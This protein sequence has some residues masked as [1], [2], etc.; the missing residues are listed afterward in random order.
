MSNN[1]KQT[2]T[3]PWIEKHRTMKLNDIKINKYIKN[4]LDMMIKKY[5]MPNIILEGPSG[6]GKTSTII[7]IARELYKKYYKYMVLEMNASDNRGIEI[8]TI[9]DNFRKL[10]VNIEEQDK[11]HVPQFKMIILDE[12]DNMT[13]KAENIISSFIKNYSDKI[14]F[15]FTCNSKENIISSIQSNCYIIKYP[16][17]ED[18]IIVSRLQEICLIE[19]I[20]TKTTNKK[21]IKATI[22]GLNCIATITNGDMRRAINV[23]QITYCRFG[24]INV[25]N[26][27]NVQDIPQPEQLKYIIVN[28]INGD[29]SSALKKVIEIRHSG[30]SGTDIIIGLRNILRIDIC[31]DIDEK[32]KMEIS[33]CIHH[34]YNNIAHGLDSSVLQITACIADIYKNT[35]IKQLSSV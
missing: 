16:P 3:L 25:E 9:I 29:I 28:C 34:A 18:K 24:I 12:A 27:Y 23:L 7:C 20:I 21:N 35:Y 8:F 4:Q 6:V 15:A 13:E 31:S 22:D 33:K 1:D 26:V 5:D 17:L 10:F 19:N 11:K 32:T 14:R 30:Y 2:N